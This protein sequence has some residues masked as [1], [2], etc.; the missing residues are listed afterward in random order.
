MIHPTVICEH[1]VC[2]E[3]FI[4]VLTD[5]HPHIRPSLFIRS[6]HLVIE[7]TVLAIDNKTH[8][9]SPVVSDLHSTC[10]GT[11]NLISNVSFKRRGK[12]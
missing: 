1:A 11:S 4:R 10:N 12:S 9:F 8:S 7:F 6:K 5:M 2:I 3:E